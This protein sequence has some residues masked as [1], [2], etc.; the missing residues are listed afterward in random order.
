MAITSTEAAERDRKGAFRLGLGA[1]LGL[2]AAIIAIVLP[3]VA[4]FTSTYDPGGFFS[5]APTLLQTSSALVLAG[6]V[7]FL[8]SLFLYR[9]AFAGLR[10]VNPDFTLASFLCLLGFVGFILILVAAAVVAGNA[11]SL[12]GCIQGNP[13]HALTCMQANQPLGAY[14][15]IIGFIL[16][17]LGGLGIVLGLWIAGGHFGEPAL[18]LGAYIYLFF[19]LLLLAP[20]IEV[21]F[22]FEGGQFLLVLVPV[23]SFAAPALV[24]FGVLPKIRA[25]QRAARGAPATAA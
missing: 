6:A 11:S 14:T 18:H 12:L 17:W 10:K 1:W 19:L 9:W 15:A 16:A 8:L 2:F 13:A 7:L 24:L 22:P 23:L 4:I 21:A 5:F 20:L 3:S 25:D